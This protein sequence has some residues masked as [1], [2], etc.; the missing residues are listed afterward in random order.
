MFSLIVLTVLGQSAVQDVPVFSTDT[1]LVRL[2]VTVADEKK[3]P[4]TD[5]EAED[6][7][8]SEDGQWQ[9][10]VVFARHRVPV[11]VT[12]LSDASSSMTDKSTMV[13]DAMFK[14]VRAMDVGDS[15]RIYGFTDKLY[16]IQ[17]DTMDQKVLIPAVFRRNI[18][19]G[20]TALYDAVS[21][22]LENPSRCLS[23]DVNCRRAVV[24]LSDGVDTCSSRTFSDAVD[25]VR[26]SDVVVYSV[27]MP[28][29]QEPS[30]PNA[31]RAREFLGKIAEES[32]G[33]MFTVITGQGL[34]GIYQTIG[35]EIHTQYTLGYV[36]SNVRR[37]GQ[38]RKLRVGVI[39]K[40]R[41]RFTVRHRKGYYA[42]RF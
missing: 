36:Q 39:G 19:S 12:L 40:D 26:S 37:D 42:P 8:I 18:F 38:W 1:N 20:F 32:G 23:A 3:R 35:H 31:M 16:L 21:G 24:V 29:E 7:V 9:E 34:A 5:L 22:V 6:F 11:S 4:V 28:V 33:R 2:Q 27:A 15:A 25:A 41:K 30:K 17:N 13:Q 14:F 10:L